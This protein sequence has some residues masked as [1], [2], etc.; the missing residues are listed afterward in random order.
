[1]WKRKK[2]IGNES[3]SKVMKCTREF[4]GKRT[5]VAVYSKLLEVKCCKYF[6]SKVIVNKLI[7]T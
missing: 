7:E 1:M 4:G 5:N 3:K 2:L 6:G